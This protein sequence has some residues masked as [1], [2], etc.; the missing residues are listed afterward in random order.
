MGRAQGSFQSA[1][2]GLDWV[3]V[4][5]GVLVRGTPAEE[6]EAVVAAHAD[7]GVQRGWIAKEAPRTEIVVPGFAIARTP[8]TWKQWTTFVEEAGPQAGVEPGPADHPVDGVRWEQ[9]VMFCGWL[10]DRTGLPVRLPTEIEWERAARGGDSREYPWG[11]T[12]VAGRANLI[13][14]AV[15]GTCP[16]GS[17]PGGVSPFGVLDL[18]GNVDEW[19]LDR[20]VPYPGAPPGVPKVEDW[21]GDP[22]VTRGGGFFHG[23]EFNRRYGNQLMRA[24]VLLQG[25]T[26]LLLALYFLGAG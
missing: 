26:L 8:V 6:V 21:A 20:Y 22:H 2:D 15:G 9:A 10:A 18:A 25:V 5:A 19:T 3:E 23:G 12:Y 7:L 17:F 16:V 24:R 1:R 14:A 11:D 13:D 4:P